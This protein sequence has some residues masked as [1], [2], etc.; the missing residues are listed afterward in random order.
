MKE[1]T[2]IMQNIISTVSALFVWFVVY[3]LL[4][5]VFTVC[6]E[7]EAFQRLLKY[8]A[9]HVSMRNAYKLTYVMAYISATAAAACVIS[10]TARCKRIIWPGVLT[11][12]VV[13]VFLVADFVL[14]RLIDNNSL[15]DYWFE[16]ELPG[17]DFNIVSILFNGGK[18][19][20]ISSLLRFL[21]LCLVYYYAV[22][23]K[24]KSD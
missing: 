21:P 23:D 14:V 1:R 15:P 8:A 3:Y 7:Y 2:H 22:K 5:F 24:N 16:I 19:H 17:M 20:I 11:F 18:I 9:Q 10:S 4:C 6:L 12:F 13:Y